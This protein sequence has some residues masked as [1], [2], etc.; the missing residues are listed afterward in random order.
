MAN[1]T[2]TLKVSVAW[3][4]KPYLYCVALMCFITRQEPNMDKVGYWVGKA[5][6]ITEG[7]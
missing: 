2:L 7:K 4:I 3:W 5:I 6:K 1:A